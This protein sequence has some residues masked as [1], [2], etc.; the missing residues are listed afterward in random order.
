MT[1]EQK[2]KY[3]WMTDKMDY[4]TD[5]NAGDF[6][7]WTYLEPADVKSPHKS[8]LGWAAGTEEPKSKRAAGCGEDNIYRELLKCF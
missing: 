3:E 1:G 6:Y 7:L 5:A 8:E 4:Y 2:Q